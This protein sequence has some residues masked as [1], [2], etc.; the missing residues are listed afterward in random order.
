IDGHV[1][2]PN[3]A[4]T[5]AQR[6]A[7]SLA[8]SYM[9][10]SPGVPIAGT[11]ID[12][13]FIGS[14]T[15]GRLSDFEAAA[16]IVRGRRV[17]PGVTAWAVPGSQAVKTEAESHGIADILK[18]AGI[19]WREPGCSSCVAVNGEVVP[20]GQRAVSTTNR[21]FVGRQG[22]QARTHLASPEIAAA[23]AITGV[24]TDPRHLD[25]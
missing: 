18:S 2:D 3:A 12:R 11:P 19:E 21:N 8:L 4:P 25:D 17:A 23:S 10:L 13:V 7:W 9:G 16:A 14:C 5:A 1:P 20:P 24:I 6:Q 15:N 22:P